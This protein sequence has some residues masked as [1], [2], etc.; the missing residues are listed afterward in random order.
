MDPE[1]L[2]GSGTRKV[3]SW[4]GSG[5]NH[6]GSTTLSITHKA[7][8]QKA[9]NYDKCL[10]QLSNMTKYL[11]IA[12]KCLMPNGQT[13]IKITPQTDTSEELSFSEVEFLYLLSLVY[14]GSRVH[15]FVC[16][17]R[18]FVK[19]YCVGVPLKLYAALPYLKWCSEQK[20]QN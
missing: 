19:I 14:V 7:T 20:Q 12:T 3:Q 6:S 10:I 17:F 5:I 16:L 18:H 1:L 15:I 8:G 13:L 11:S 9:S 4:I 2:P